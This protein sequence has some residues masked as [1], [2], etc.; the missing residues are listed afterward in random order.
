MSSEERDGGSRAS[1]QSIPPDVPAGG[2]LPAAPSAVFV[3]AS[4]GGAIGAALGAMALLASASLKVPI[5]Y[6]VVF[7]TLPIWTAAGT[8]IALRRAGYRGAV[9]AG[10][11]AFI[12][13]I[14]FV[15]APAF[16]V[17]ALPAGLIGLAAAAL[18][19]A[20]AGLAS[21]AIERRTKREVRKK[22]DTA[23]SLVVVLVIAAGMTA[24]LII[25]FSQAA[26]LAA[27]LKQPYSAGNTPQAAILCR[28][29]MTETCAQRAADRTQIVTAWIPDTDRYRL[30]AMIAVPGR[31]FQGLSVDGDPYG[32]IEISTRPTEVPKG[33][34]VTDFPTT[35]EAALYREGIA[36]R[37]SWY[38]LY[39][40]R[41]E[42]VYRISVSGFW[43]APSQNDVTEIWKQVRYAV[44]VLTEEGAS[45][46]ADAKSDGAAQDPK[47]GY[48]SPEPNQ[49]D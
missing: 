7:G 10:S 37:L 30:D 45:E 34:R 46:A 28:G 33:T 4:L 16:F 40:V 11:W 47:S 44:P 8:W 25:F 13:A 38:T 24:V 12:L 35:E 9:T 41:D 27:Q 43:K 3:P 29:Q 31:A 18:G 14:V 19:G 1:E 2:D 5:A 6:A 39:W 15:F 48:P 49:S 36:G 21:I 17:P 42:V 23:T 22:G 26:T 20:L 32:L